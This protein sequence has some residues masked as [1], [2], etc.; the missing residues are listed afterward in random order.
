MVISKEEKILIESLY[1]AKVMVCTD[2]LNSFCRE[3]LDERWFRQCM[4]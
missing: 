1:E 3:K 4:C 2:F